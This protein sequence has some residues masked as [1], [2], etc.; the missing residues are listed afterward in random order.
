[1][2]WYI[3]RKTRNFKPHKENKIREYKKRDVSEQM[4]FLPLVF[5]F[6]LS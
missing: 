2:E 4:P 5:L 6:L 3:R 1:M